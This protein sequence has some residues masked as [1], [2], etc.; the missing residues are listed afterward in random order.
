M[1]LAR[2]IFITNLRK[3]DK[4]Q[5]K[6]Q[7]KISA[8]LQ[9]C[10]NCSNSNFSPIPWSSRSFCTEDLLE[11]SFIFLFKNSVISFLVISLQSIMDL[12][13]TSLPCPEMSRDYSA[14]HCVMT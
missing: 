8:K 4:I 9:Y 3:S 12:L 5:M 7:F 11:G 2:K 1:G 14:E 13:S 10:G 6:T